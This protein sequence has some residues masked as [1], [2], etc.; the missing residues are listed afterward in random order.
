MPWSTSPSLATWRPRS[1]P[2]GGVGCCCWPRV[3]TRGWGESRP[4]PTHS[5]LTT[6]LKIAT[7]VLCLHTV[8][9]G[10]LVSGYRHDRWRAGSRCSTGSPD[11]L[12]A[13]QNSPMNYSRGW[14]VIFREW[15]VRRAPGWRIGQCPV[16]HFP[17]HS[18]S[19]SIF[20][21]VPN[22]ISFL[23]CVEPYAPIIDEF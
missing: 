18:K 16:H 7:W 17:A 1:R 6:R 4:G 15:L 22:L 5:S 3:V 20:N 11:S 19:C 2:R 23:V 8:V 10:T 21:Y 12:V 13:H 9:R 14:P